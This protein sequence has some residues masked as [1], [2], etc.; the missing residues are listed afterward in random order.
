LT[1]VTDPASV[2]LRYMALDS[3]VTPLPSDGLF[4]DDMHV[5]LR[6]PS[7]PGVH[8]DA[9]MATLYTAI[10]GDGLPLTQDQ[11]LCKQVTGSN[12]LL[13]NPALVLHVSIGAS[14]VA[15][16]NVIGNLF[17][18][19]VV[20][21]RQLYHGET[22]RTVTGV[23]A[24]ADT[25][26]KPNVAP[27]GKVVLSISTST[28]DGDIVVDYE[29]CPLLPCRGNDAPGLADEIG[30][31]A[32]EL[33]LARFID[34]VPTG[35]DL[36]GLGAHDHWDLGTTR[37][38][39]QRDVVDMATALVRITHNQA[40]V[41]RDTEASSY[42]G[43]L[44][45]GGHTVA[46]AQASLGRVLSGMATVVGWHSCNHSAPVFEEDILSCSHTLVDQAAVNGGVL[47]AVH[48]EVKAHRKG[49]ESTKVLDWTPIVYTT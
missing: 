48:I 31:A 6:F 3:H 19:N 27:R 44:V 34:A 30:P 29:R 47:R 39:L 25:R 14:T 5:G 9:S 11:S 28:A 2:L 42:D 36:D 37:N 38:D 10:C 16:R 1:D 18:R 43:R 26:P 33:D 22:L 8:I 23:V 41:H 32:P 24:M 12:A 17:Y 13:V 45:Y 40:A 15:T 35:W 49:S 20:L 21:A 7:P 4:Y 46:L